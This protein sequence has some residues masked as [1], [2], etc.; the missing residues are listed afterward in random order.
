MSYAKLKHL[1]FSSISTFLAE[2]KTEDTEADS[3]IKKETTNL[4][5]TSSLLI[6]KP[7]SKWD[8]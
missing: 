3:S 2:E 7:S 4:K 8:W 5:P 6:S 1:C